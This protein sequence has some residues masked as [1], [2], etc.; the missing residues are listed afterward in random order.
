MTH[1]YQLLIADSQLRADSAFQ[2][3]IE[4][5]GFAFHFV[6]G[7]NEVLE[8]LVENDVDLL[9]LDN[10]SQQDTDFTFLANLRSLYT[11]KALAILISTSFAASKD[12]EGALK[13]GADDVLFTDSDPALNVARL[14][15]LMVNKR[16][17]DALVQQEVR[18][19][20]AANGSRDG[21]FDWDLARDTVYYSDNWK[22]MLGIGFAEDPRNKEDWFSRVHE[23]D[24]HLL[25]AKL[26][27]HMDGVTP[28]FECQYRI[29]HG[30]GHYVWVLCRGQCQHNE[31]HVAVRM[32]GT[33]TDLTNRSLHDKRTGLPFR[34]YFMERLNQ[35]LAECQ[36]TEEKHFAILHVDIDSFKV[37]SEGYGYGTVDKLLVGIARR[38]EHCLGKGDMLAFLGGDSFVI[39]LP[40]GE[41]LKYA[42][43]V[44]N[45]IHLQLI[46][47]FQIQ[48]AEVFA[49]ASIGVALVSKEAR[50]P[51]ELLRQAQTAM[52]FAREMGS[53]HTEVFG[54]GMTSKGR[55]RMEIEAALRSALDRNEFVLFYQPQVHLRTNKIIGAEALIRWVRE[56]GT[57]IPPAQFVPVAEETDLILT[58]GEWVLRTACQ[59]TVY[60]QS[61]G[62]PPLRVGVNI[63]ERQF[64][65]RNLVGI[66]RTILEETGLAPELLELEI[67]ESIFMEDTER[68][69]HILNQFRDL[70]I[71]IALDDFGTG[72]SSLSYLKRIPFTTLKIDKAF[73]DDLTTN[74]ND[75]AIC[76]TIIDLGHKFNMEVITEGVE[77]ED[78]VKILRAF[79]CDEIQGYFFSKPL[80]AREFEELLLLKPSF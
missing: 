12:V 43:Q 63:S 18:F 21:L 42:H 60:W 15:A 46:A 13:Q 74:V 36:I 40:D 10:G 73:V 52:K 47:P 22:T 79:L 56:D 66:V 80:P 5:E 9:I 11:R 57:T 50:N 72:Y 39:L 6:D 62:L 3:N 38:F 37:V 68:A 7:P 29:L 59:Q 54:V 49:K 23:D 53:G 35:A 48:E 14:K 78:Q 16:S 4:A 2:K 70:G 33:L 27:V 26:A 17:M 51:E 76:S 8:Q 61:M 55:E 44:A 65:A 75:A 32:V 28:F 69:L 41:E 24:L 45:Q 58:I 30:M 77:H 1:A 20:M 71:K 64:R 25:K 67:T 34:D 31:D 19:E